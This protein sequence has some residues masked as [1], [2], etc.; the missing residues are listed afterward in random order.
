MIYVL[1]NRIM[2]QV[3]VFARIST[4]FLE[5]LATEALLS[6]SKITTILVGF[7]SGSQEMMQ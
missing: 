4:I 3:S 2:H 1:F 7:I 6:G 5:L